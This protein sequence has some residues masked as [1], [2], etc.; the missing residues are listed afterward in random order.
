[1]APLILFIFPCIF[2]VLAGPAVLNLLDK[3]VNNPNL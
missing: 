2:V 1:M 3:W